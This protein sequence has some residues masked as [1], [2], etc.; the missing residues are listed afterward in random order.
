MGSAVGEAALC[1][2]G[3]HP[4]NFKQN[5]TRGPACVSLQCTVWYWKHF[6]PLSW[7][8]DQVLCPIWL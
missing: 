1:E 3:S 7:L 2:G 8:V 6:L 5:V 4:M